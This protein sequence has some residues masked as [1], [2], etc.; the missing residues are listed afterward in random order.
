M[1]PINL[2]KAI[3]QVKEKGYNITPEQENAIREVCDKI[4][5]EIVNCKRSDYQRNGKT[6]DKCIEIIDKYREV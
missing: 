6:Y 5:A 3:E 2:E 1:T 4:K